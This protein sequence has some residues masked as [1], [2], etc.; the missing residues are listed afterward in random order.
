MRLSIIT[1]ILVTL[2]CSSCIEESA[3]VSIDGNNPPTFKLSGSGVPHFCVIGEDTGKEEKVW[4]SNVIWKIEPDAEGRQLG[5]WSISPLIFGKVPK[6]YIQ[7]F[8][9]DHPPSPLQEGMKYYF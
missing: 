2:F 5:V 9:K 7:T 1:L 4:P 8:P 3:T 6:G